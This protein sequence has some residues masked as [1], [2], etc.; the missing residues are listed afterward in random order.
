MAANEA[1]EYSSVSKPMSIEGPVVQ[2][3]NADMPSD[4]QNKAVELAKA[5]VVKHQQQMSTGG[6]CLSPREIA[7]T[8]KKEFDQLYGH[9][10]HCIVGK[11]FGSFV[12]H[13][14]INLATI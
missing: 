9:T 7:G 5:T 3:K 1:N 14:T 13:G 10:W 8:L 12:T 11:S 2:I 4:M 6:Q